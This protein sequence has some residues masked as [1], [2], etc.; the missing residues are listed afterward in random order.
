VD[1]VLEWADTTNRDFDTSFMV[2]MQDRLEKCQSLSNIQEEAIDNVIHKHEI[3][4]DRW[5]E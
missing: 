4:L 2:D 3:D 5:V 1:A